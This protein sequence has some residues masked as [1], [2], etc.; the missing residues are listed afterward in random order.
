MGNRRVNNVSRGQQKSVL[1]LTVV[2]II[3]IIILTIINFNKKPEDKLLTTAK[4]KISQK[5]FIVCIDPGHGGYDI[6]CTSKSGINEKEITLKVALMLGEKLDKQNI[7]VVY[8]RDSDVVSWPANEKLDIRERV[9]ISNDSKA[10]LFISIHCNE[11]KESYVDGT[12]IWCKN[13]NSEEE[14]LA[15]QIDEE[16]MKLKYTKS[17]GIKYESQKSLGV[18]RTNKATAVL[19]ELGYVSNASDDKYLTSKKGQENCATALEKAVLKY[20]DSLKKET[21]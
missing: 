9:K 15:K 2:T 20:K 8:T 1:I 14:K 4:S 7:E 17:R 12:E 11:F 3:S 10:D 5:N 18:L 6:G 21:K 13:P 16:L 19:V